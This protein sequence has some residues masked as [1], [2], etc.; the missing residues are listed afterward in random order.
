MIRSTIAGFAAGAALMYFVDPVRGRRR[1]AVARDKFLAE[2]RDLRD[3]LDKAGRD[4]RNRSHGLTAGISAR[5]KSET[6]DGP[7]L[8]E[9][10][11]SVIGRAIS[12]PHAI[13][14]RAEPNGRIMLEGPVLRHEVDYLLKRVRAVRDVDGIEDQQ[15]RNER[16]GDLHGHSD[17]F[18]KI[19]SSP[20]RF[21][22]AA[23]GF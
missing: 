7:V 10:V 18:G 22:P 23:A 9:R 6:A 11:R 5:W 21:V 16:H 19:L 8:V 1:R 12:H 3:E 4:V 14:V 20:L 15:Y 2:C 17:N 13:R